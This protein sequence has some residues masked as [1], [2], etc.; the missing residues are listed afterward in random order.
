ML[1]GLEPSTDNLNY[2]IS[3]N[4]K[5]ILGR[6]QAEGLVIKELSKAPTQCEKI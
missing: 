6:N 1:E 2:T 3:F 5:D 4:A